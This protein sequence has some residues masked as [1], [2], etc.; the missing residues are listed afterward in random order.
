MEDRYCTFCEKP[1]CRNRCACGRGRGTTSHQLVPLEEENYRLKWTIYD[2]NQILYS[3]AI[4]AINKKERALLYEKSIEPTKE[5]RLVD[6][7]CTLL[8][9][10]KDQPLTRVTKELVDQQ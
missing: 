8:K 4:A 9:T 3:K 2:M 10:C 5:G 7:I 6:I 1:V